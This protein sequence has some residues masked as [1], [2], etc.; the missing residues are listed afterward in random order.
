MNM[1][2]ALKN[3]F[4]DVDIKQLDPKKH[5]NFLITRIAEKGGV[6]SVDWLKKTF[7]KSKI[8]QVVKS[9]KNVSA[10]TKNYWS[11]I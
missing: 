2:N 6:K 9:S 4:W 5:A 1:N 3:L 10:K 11:V 7:G 8:R